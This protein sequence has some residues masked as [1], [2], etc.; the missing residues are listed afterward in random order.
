LEVDF[1]IGTQVNS[2]KMASIFI[3]TNLYQISYT[4]FKK[5]NTAYI[6]RYPSTHT[7]RMEEAVARIIAIS[8]RIRYLFSE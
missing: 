8:A 1:I 2:T 4:E 6:F 3:K 5:S 7:W